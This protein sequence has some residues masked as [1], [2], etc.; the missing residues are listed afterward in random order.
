MTGTA[1][2]KDTSCYIYKGLTLKILG[3]NQ[4]HTNEEYNDIYPVG[5]VTYKLSLKG[6]EWDDRD[7]TIIHES[8]LE[9]IK[10]EGSLEAELWYNKLKT[11]GQKVINELF[12]SDNLKSVDEIYEAF[13]N[14]KVRQESFKIYDEYEATFTLTQA[15]REAVIKR[16]LDY[17]IKHDCTCGETLHQS[18]DCLIDAPNVLSDI[19]DNI[20]E[21]KTNL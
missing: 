11:E 14:A 9:D 19:I 18:D 1:K 16:I 13:N 20:L 3:V 10:T 15:K 4:H 8:E 6:T 7:Y 17:M 5:S 2:V 12:N 21:V